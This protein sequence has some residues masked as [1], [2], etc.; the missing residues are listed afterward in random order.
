MNEQEKKSVTEEQEHQEHL[1]YAGDRVMEQEDFD[2]DPAQAF[3][4]P[5]V[6]KPLRAVT[7]DVGLRADYEGFA[8]N[9]GFDENFLKA[10]AKV[11]G[12]SGLLLDIGKA[13]NNSIERYV[14][15]VKN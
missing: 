9:V 3:S 5:L 13:V 14:A 1:T 12:I 7:V 11:P 6:G 4:V 8:I 10:A 15:T 2:R